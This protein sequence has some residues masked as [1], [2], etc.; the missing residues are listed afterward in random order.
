MPTVSSAPLHIPTLSHSKRTWSSRTLSV[1]LSTELDGM[2]KKSKE[3]RKT[4]FDER[5]VAVEVS[6]EVDAGADL[7]VTPGTAVDEGKSGKSDK[8]ASLI[9]G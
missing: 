5:W 3:T 8:V 1:T 2:E 9:S 6:V 7:V 4:M